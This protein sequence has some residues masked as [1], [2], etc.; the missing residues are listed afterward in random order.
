MKAAAR[1][2]D[3]CS[4]HG[5]FKPREAIQG[6]PDVFINNR[7]ALRKGDKWA[8]HSSGS[9]HDG[10]LMTGSS[11]VFVNN[12][13]LGRIDDQI[14]P[15]PCLSKVA[16]GSPNVF[17]GESGFGSN[18]NSTT[19]SSSNNLSAEPESPDRFAA[20]GGYSGAGTIGTETGIN[21]TETED[22]ENNDPVDASD[23]DIDWLTT[24]MMDEA[25][26]Q[27]S[28]DAWA[29]V[30]QVVLNRRNSNYQGNPVNP[31]WQ[32]TIKGFVLAR[33]AFS[34]FYF[35]MING[36]YTR[37]AS[38][39]TQAETRGKQKM[40]RYRRYSQWNIFHNVAQ[41]VVAGTYNGSP[42]WRLV[43]SRNSLLYLNPSISRTAWATPAKFIVKI[44]SHAF[45]KA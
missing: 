17:V 25:L 15:F 39:F 40:A 41:Q 31:S 35:E 23:D 8:I 44:E 42:S 27:K 43:K 7:P 20:A 1:K 21:D 12:K 34:G 19:N 5:D 9:S 13:P 14:G 29:A 16:S 18:T 2:G 32:G 30:A 37:V 33:N 4:G 26:N 3:K 45:Y 11:S 22:P 38:S 24:C 28:S 10:Q 36:R 6:S